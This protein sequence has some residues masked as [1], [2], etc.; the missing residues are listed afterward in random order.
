MGCPS[1]GHVRSSSRLSIGRMHDDA[2]SAAARRPRREAVFALRPGDDSASY[3][4][5]RRR[6]RRVQYVHAREPTR[7]LARGYG[8]D[9][10]IVL[11]AI[12]GM[13]EVALRQRLAGRAARRRRGSPSRRSRSSCC[14]SSRAA[15]SPSPRPRSVWLL[16]AAL[17]FVDGRLIAFSASLFVVGMAAAFLLGNLRDAVQARIGLAD[18]ARRRGDRRLQQ[19]R[20]QSP[21]SSSSSPPVRDRL[22]RRL[23]PARAGRAGRGGRGA[24]GRRPSASARRRHASRS[25]RSARGSRASSTTSSPTP[26]A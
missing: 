3:P 18:R 7:S 25:P 16:A 19:P 17:S 13:L 21:A 8:F 15:A 22:A 12:A 11:A 6:A 5:R 24:R 26:S 14:R 1:C 4:G 2:R 10:L 23:R 20:P 9:A